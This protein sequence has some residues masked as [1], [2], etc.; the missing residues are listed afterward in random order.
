MALYLLFE[1][2]AVNYRPVLINGILE[3]SYPSSTTMLVL[4]VMPTALIELRSSVQNKIL[5]R[6]IFAATACFVAFMVVSRGVCGVHWITD[7]IGGVLISSGLVSLY[8]YFKGLK[9]K[10]L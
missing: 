7:I 5:S 10:Q 9:F 1:I 4:C 6:G 3:A 8:C 2:I